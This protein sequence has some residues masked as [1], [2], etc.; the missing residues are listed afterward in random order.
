MGRGCPSGWV[1]GCVLGVQFENCSESTNPG[2]APAASRL[3]CLALTARGF[4]FQDMALVITLL[5]AG[6][7]LLLAETILP[8]MIAGILG[9]GCLVAG[10]VAG[11]TEF[12]AQTGHWILLGVVLGLVLGFWL[13]L[14]Y[15]P[16]SRVGKMFVSRRVVGDIGTAKPELMNQTGTAYTNLRPAGVAIINGQRVDVVTEGPMIPRDAP[17]KVVQIEGARVVVRAI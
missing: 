11:Y 2:G 6:A 9:L 14:K 15:F 17:V 12:D 4:Y 16:D 5:I 3:I 13:W 1:R 7:L 8:G 10:V